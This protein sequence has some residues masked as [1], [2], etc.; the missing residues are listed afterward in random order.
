ME[1][2]SR[3]PTNGNIGRDNPIS[4]ISQ[5]YNEE[6]PKTLPSILNLPIP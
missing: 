3:S 2:R 5:I 4:E 6:L 1:A